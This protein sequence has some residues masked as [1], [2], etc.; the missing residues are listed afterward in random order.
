MSAEASPG[1]YL[2]K[3]LKRV[4]GQVTLIERRNHHLFQ[5]MLYQVATAALNP[6]DIAS[7]IRSILRRQRNVDVILGDVD[8][9]DLAA[10]QVHLADG[11]AI[12]Y[13]YCAVATGARHSYY[14]HPEWE[15]LAPGIKSLADALEVRRRI[16]LAFER[17]EREPDAQRRQ[18]LLTFVVVGG[19]PT[20]VEVAGA[21]AE[22]RRYA[23][24]RD[25]R[26][27][28]PR[29]A[30]VVLLEG[31]P[32]ILAAYPPALSARDKADLRKLGV[33]VRENSFVTAIHP[34]AVESAGWRIPTNTVVWAAGNQASP[35]LR[36]L[37]VPLDGQ[38]RVIVESDCTIPGH[39]EVMVLGDAAAFKDL[40]AG[41]LVPAVCPA[42]IQ[43]GQFAARAIRRT[44]AGKP[45][46]PFQYWNKGELAV[47]GRGDAV[48]NLPGFRFGGFFAWFIWIFLHI[49]YLIGFR[50]RLLVLIEWA[51]SYVTYARGA[52][53]MLPSGRIEKVVMITGDGCESRGALRIGFV[54]C[55]ITHPDPSARG[56]ALDRWLA[57]GYGGTM[58]YLHRQAKKRKRP[59]DIT[60]GAQTVI[61]VLENYAAP[62]DERPQAG[63]AI[64]IA[65][66][67]RGMDY[68]IVT[69]GR[70]HILTQWLKQHG[71]KLAHAW[72]DDGPVP[73]RELAERAGLGWI[74][75][76]TMLI[77]PRI[78]S[79]TFI[80]TI[81]TDLVLAADAPIATDLCGT[82]T[83]C[84]DACPT[85]AFV[86]E[87]VLDATKCLS[88]LTIEYKGA[89][90]DDL[91]ARS[92]GWAFGCDVCNDACPWNEKFARP[93]TVDEF[94]ARRDPDRRDLSVFDRMTEDR[95]RELFADTPLARP[96]LERM[97]RN[98]R[99]VGRTPTEPMTP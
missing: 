96:G 40:K 17:A 81:F 58:R 84:L 25:F 90:P 56:E 30:T 70:M 87:R 39:S 24:A 22:I 49:T 27:I 60:P 78:G 68:H 63:D 5:P 10:R 2:A 92:G 7:P 76:N 33:D 43:M 35:L 85:G 80:G 37:G 69:L 12:G 77:H 91:A 52:R 94:A 65:S 59:A 18:N 31:G 75:K 83:R 95:F 13:D 86:G 6:A 51:W 34:D 88:Y 47:I 19:G 73:D 4:P 15:A 3:G 57:A 1:F 50:N 79:Y 72:V 36:T 99:A 66:Y 53:L 20:G 62:A 93:T 46:T 54:A 26:H 61:V 45:R 41:S 29:E 21:L 28:D 42:A 64:K 9:I 32:R 97:R 89:M 55:G 98:V 11:T 67:A 38:G 16:F 23:L 44:V 71:A 8:R 14:G 48:A 74:G 82:C